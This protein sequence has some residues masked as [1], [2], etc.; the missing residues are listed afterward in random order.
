MDFYEILDFCAFD[1]TKA[2]EMASQYL[3]QPKAVEEATK[4]SGLGKLES[5]P[6]GK[7]SW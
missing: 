3:S 2:S 6:D 7:D 5:E 4:D 1:V